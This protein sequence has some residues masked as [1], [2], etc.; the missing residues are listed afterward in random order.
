MQSTMVPMMWIHS[1]MKLPVMMMMMMMMLSVLAVAEA[2]TAMA[3]A[4]AA[5]CV[6]SRWICSTQLTP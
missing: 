6:Y 5:S 1:S 3:M 4:Q 2:E